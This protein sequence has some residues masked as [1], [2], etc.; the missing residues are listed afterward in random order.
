MA[1]DDIKVDVDLLWSGG[2][3]GWT[4]LHGGKR[5]EPPHDGIEEPF[6]FVGSLD[7]ME[8]SDRTSFQGSFQTDDQ[9]WQYRRPSWRFALITIR[10]LSGTLQTS[11]FRLGFKDV[12]QMWKE[13]LEIPNL[14]ETVDQIYSEVEPLYRQLYAF[15]RGR[16]AETD[17]SIR[18][19]RPLPAHLLG[20]FYSRHKVLASF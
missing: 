5:V 2:Q 4:K 6:G 8:A 10:P 18:A 19:D 9:T 11:S 16:L 14:E 17:S 7:R 12:S 13:E 15:V 3:R 20:N 1:G